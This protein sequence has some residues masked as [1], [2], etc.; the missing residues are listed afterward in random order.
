MSTI[1]IVILFTKISSVK[2][3]LSFCA[4]VPSKRFRCSD[5]M[6]PHCLCTGAEMEPKLHAAKDLAAAFAVK[7]DVS[8]LYKLI[9]IVLLSTDLSL[10]DTAS[11]PLQ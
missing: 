3:L 10:L 1:H 5:L 6:E 2:V 11:F 7:E 9:L 8:L 4:V